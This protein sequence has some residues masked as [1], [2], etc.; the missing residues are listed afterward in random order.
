V[1]Q[2]QA[3]SHQ[4][5]Q[6]LVYSPGAKAS[7]TDSPDD[8]SRHGLAFRSRDLLLEGVP[9]DAAG[10]T[11]SVLSESV[12]LVRPYSW[13]SR[14]RGPRWWRVSLTCSDVCGP[15][16]GCVQTIHLTLS[17]MKA[18]LDDMRRDRDAW[19][20]QAQGLDEA[21]NQPARA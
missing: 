21:V 7:S 9:R 8:Y 5:I 19:G 14:S 11:V 1:Q 20:N 13:L 10:D 16:T 18:M 2:P 3:F 6:K 15:F 17:D 4:L 12:R